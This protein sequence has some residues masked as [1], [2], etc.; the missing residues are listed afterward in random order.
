M[1]PVC[2][3]SELRI[4]R[5]VIR[6]SGTRV[7]NL[8]LGSYDFEG[9]RPVSAVQDEV[10][11]V[12]CLSQPLPKH[13]LIFAAQLQIRRRGVGAV[14]GVFM[15]SHVSVV[16]CRIHQGR[17]G[18]GTVQQHERVYHD[19]VHQERYI[20]QEHR[21]GKATLTSCQ[22]TITSEERRREAFTKCCADT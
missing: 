20:Y 11:N 3:V 22:I 6:V 12:I 16:Q 2:R 18:M 13:L 15:C 14:H 9:V 1:Q 4:S 17:R 7:S 21:R 10:D 19:K 5:P 8:C